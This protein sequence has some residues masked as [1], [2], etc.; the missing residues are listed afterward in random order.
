MGIIALACITTQMLCS[1]ICPIQVPN[2]NNVSN[3]SSKAPLVAEHRCLFRNM[4]S[5]RSPSSPRF[6]S[7]ERDR[8]G[9]SG[10]HT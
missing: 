4:L 10:D 7:G 1:N 3:K 8:S 6:A 2:D 9:L 5:S